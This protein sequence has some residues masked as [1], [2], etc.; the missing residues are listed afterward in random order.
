MAPLA[1]MLSKAATQAAMAILVKVA[2]EKFFV[3][4]YFLAAERLAEVTTNKL[5]DEFVK[6][7]KALYYEEGGTEVASTKDK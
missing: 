1:L 4:L 6:K 3:W 2:S 7:S 5:D